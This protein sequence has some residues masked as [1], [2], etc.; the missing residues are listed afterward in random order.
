MQPFWYDEQ[1]HPEIL[2][3]PFQH[4]LDGTWFEEF[5]I[6]RG[7]EFAGVLEGAIDEIVR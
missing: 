6:D 1:Q 4:W 7:A 3:I 2:E 5:G